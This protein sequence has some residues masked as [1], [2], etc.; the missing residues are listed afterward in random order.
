MFS[1]VPFFRYDFGFLIMWV[2][3]YS[4]SSQW[5]EI[6]VGVLNECYLQDK[7]MAHELLVRDIETWG[8]STLLVISDTAEQMDFM[9]HS[10]CQTKLNKIWKGKMALYTSS[11]KVLTF[12]PLHENLNLDQTFSNMF[13]RVSF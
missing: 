6:A 1:C 8:G 11:W 5:E 12:Y 4:L 13:F 3:M 9:G 7:E 2:Y 10:C